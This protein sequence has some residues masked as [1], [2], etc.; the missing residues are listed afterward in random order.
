MHRRRVLCLALFGKH[1][2]GQWSR[3]L[4]SSERRAIFSLGKSE[5]SSAAD[6]EVVNTRVINA[7]RELVFRAFS[8]P[9]HLAEELEKIKKAEGRLKR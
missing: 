1:I 4:A 7:P 6:R 3:L 2:G 5:A 9:E 8:E